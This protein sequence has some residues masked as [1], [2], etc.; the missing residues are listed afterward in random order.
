MTILYNKNGVEVVIQHMVD[1]KQ[2]IES[3]NYFADSPIVEN[4]PEKIIKEEVKKVKP[5][6]KPVEKIKKDF[7]GKVDKKKVEEKKF[8]DVIENYNNI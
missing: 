2:A 4:K 5:V 6:R 3:G 7:M 8:P 1:V